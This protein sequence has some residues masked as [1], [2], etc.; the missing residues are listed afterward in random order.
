LNLFSQPNEFTKL[1]LKDADIFYMEE[2]YLPKTSAQL[3][4]ELRQEIKWQQDD[5]KI[6]G[7][8]YLQPR[9]TA[10]YAENNKP[11]T[12]S[13]ITMN[14]LPFL[15]AL[16]RIKN[17]IETATT[18]KFTTCLA[19]LYRTGSDSNG[20]HSDN[21]KELGNQPVI[22]S[23][24]LGETRKFQLK[25]KDDKSQ[26]FN[27]DLPSGSLLIMKGNTQ[28]FWKHQIPKTKK[29]VGKRINLTFRSIQ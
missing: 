1:P 16:G 13:N 24:S 19:N 4:E 21:E 20:W 11:Y 2:F 17:D 22:A 28:E 10:L 15:N 29:Q 25:H 14:P 7:K 8:T 18:H 9:L 5:I 27:I 26:R 12:Y 23:L 3:F 6:F